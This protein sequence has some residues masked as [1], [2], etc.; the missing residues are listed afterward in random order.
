MYTER[1]LKLE[2]AMEDPGQSGRFWGAAGVPE[3][4]GI[5]VPPCGPVSEVQP[6]A[7][8]DMIN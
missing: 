6:A 2:Q 4:A 3:V 7:C 5:Q 8:Q 1:C